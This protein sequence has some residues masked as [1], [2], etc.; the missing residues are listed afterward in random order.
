MHTVQYRSRENIIPGIGQVHETL[1]GNECGQLSSVNLQE[2]CLQA[3]QMDVITPDTK[4]SIPILI[5]LAA[6][7]YIF[8]DHEPSMGMALVIFVVVQQRQLSNWAN[9]G[10]SF[11]YYIIYVQTL[12]SLTKPYS[13]LPI[14]YQNTRSRGL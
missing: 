8:R 1:G 5:E 3:F 6:Q 14:G 11:R 4:T 12:L 9:K 13:I 7:E 2:V 10:L